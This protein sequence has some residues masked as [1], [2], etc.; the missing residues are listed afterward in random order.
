LKHFRRAA[1]FLGAL[2]AAIL[3]FDIVSGAFAADK[4]RAGKATSETWA[5]LSLDIGVEEGIFTRYDLDVEI[6]VL[7]GGARLQQALASDS[8]DVG[9]AGSQAMALAVKGSPVT[10]VAALVGAPR[11]FAVIVPADSS[12]KTVSDLKGKTISFATNGSFPDWLVRRLSIAE[13]WG[14]DGVKGVALGSVD[15]SISAALA[16][17]VDAMMTTTEVGLLL[18]EKN[19]GRII[20]E[21]GRYAPTIVNQAVFARQ[22]FIRDQPELVARFLKGLFAAIAWMK[23]D[24]EKTVEISTRIFKQSPTVMSKAYDLELETLPDDGQFDLAGLDELKESFVELGILPEKPT[25]DQIL[26]TRFLPVKP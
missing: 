20:S 10:A 8:L 9:L 25:D 24:K 15:A 21:M 12:I 22:S 13:G 3:S 23:H 4:I 19:K 17:Q 26:T 5:Y 18:E 11:G 6:T 7:S 14:R 2:G 1:V 16:H